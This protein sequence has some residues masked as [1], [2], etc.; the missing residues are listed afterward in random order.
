MA[1]NRHESACNCGQ[2]KQGLWTQLVRIIACSAL[3]S[4]I[5]QAG[6]MFE[7]RADIQT[8]PAHQFYDSCHGSVWFGLARV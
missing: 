8:M 5:I 2:R 3:L 6:E 4:S 1:L 7:N